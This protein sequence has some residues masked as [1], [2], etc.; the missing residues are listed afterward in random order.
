MEQSYFFHRVIIKVRT[1]L[2][3]ECNGVRLS[4][5]LNY[6]FTQIVCD[7]FQTADLFVEERNVA[8]HFQKHLNTFKQANLYDD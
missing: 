5:S 1:D 3:G 2:S 8:N 4:T 6:G 7:A